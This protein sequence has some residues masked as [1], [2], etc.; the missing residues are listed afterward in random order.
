MLANI[1]ANPLTLLAPLLARLTRRGG[2]I[3]LSGVLE[4]Q[5]R[6]V[7]DAYRGEFDLDPAQ[8][9]DGWVL[10]GGSKR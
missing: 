3:L 7:Q 8:H 4:H 1:L 5:A 10:I 6:D 9:E 2:H